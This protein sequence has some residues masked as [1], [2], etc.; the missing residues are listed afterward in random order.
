MHC[1][2]PRNCSVVGSSRDHDAAP[3]RTVRPGDGCCAALMAGR[4]LSPAR[5]ALAKEL[6][7]AGG[8]FAERDLGE[9]VRENV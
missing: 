2:G 7:G 4:C 9:L 5:L 3:R 6:R 8:L 1:K